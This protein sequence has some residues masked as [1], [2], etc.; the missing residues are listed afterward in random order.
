MCPTVHTF[1]ETASPKKLRPRVKEW[2]DLM[3]RER[4]SLAMG[5]G[6]INLSAATMGT[7]LLVLKDV[8]KK[9]ECK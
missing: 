5:I 6:P 3:Y 1:V 2:V 7:F 4:P 9:T 8:T